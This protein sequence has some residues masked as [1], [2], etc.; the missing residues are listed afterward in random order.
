MFG[1][2]HSPVDEPDFERHIT[3]MTDHLT[4]VEK[5]ERIYSQ[6]EHRADAAVHILGILFAINASLWLL[7]HVTGPAR[8]RSASSSIARACS[9]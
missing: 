7:W 4:I 9:R 3:R 2:D 6:L 8:S 1:R 5:A